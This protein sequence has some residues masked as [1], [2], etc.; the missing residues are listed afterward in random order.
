[1]FKKIALGLLAAIVALLAFAAT[2][3]DTFRMQRSITIQA[4]PA[5]VFALLNDFRK[6][7]SWSPWEKLDP[8]MKRAFSGPASG[9]GQSTPGRATTPWAPGAWKSCKP[10]R[11]ARS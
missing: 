7:G 1:M 5:K 3:P 2:R 10:C 8:A 6:F 11:T 4:P 9:V